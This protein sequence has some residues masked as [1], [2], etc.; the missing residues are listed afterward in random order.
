LLIADSHDFHLQAY[1][2]ATETFSLSYEPKRNAERHIMKIVLEQK[3]VLQLTEG[4]YIESIPLSYVLKKTYVSYGNANNK[5]TK[6]RM[7]ETEVGYFMTVEAAIKTYIRE[8]IK[9]GTQ[10][11]SGNLED[12]I[13][14][15]ENITNNATDRI[16]NTVAKS[17]NGKVV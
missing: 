12:Y 10:D 1:K 3:E 2:F 9:E 11:F 5:S 17:I 7:M 4:Y 8:L 14:R 6:P 16:M 13:K 15:I